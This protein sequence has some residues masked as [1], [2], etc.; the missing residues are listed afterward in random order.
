M[1]LAEIENHRGLRS[2]TVCRLEL[3]TRKL[4]D[5]ELCTVV[6]Q[7]EY[8]LA[9]IAAD[10]CMNACR[11][12]HFAEQRRDSALA[13]GT[14]NC[15]NG[16][17]RLAQE[18]L[19]IA[20]HLGATCNC[21]PDDRRMN[22]NAGAH[23][24]AFGQHKRLRI[25]TAGRDSNV[26]QLLAQLFQPRGLLARVADGQRNTSG[27]EIARRRKAT[28]AQSDDKRPGRCSLADV[29]SDCHCRL[30]LSQRSF[31][32]ASPTRTRIRLMIQKRTMTRGSGQPLSS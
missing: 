23:D 13:V 32:V 4:E 30:H 29:C 25:E 20:N 8:R 9:K 6:K 1:I 11:S 7:L 21:F 2:Q 19:D 5:V 28:D 26:R 31:S 22:R 17:L 18:Q 3:E 15:N 27:C 14:G 24:E 10:T 12:G 16:R